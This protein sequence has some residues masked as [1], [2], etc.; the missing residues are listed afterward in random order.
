MKKNDA[1]E[2]KRFF[3]GFMDA[4][5]HVAEKSSGTLALAVIQCVV[6][7]ASVLKAG[8]LDSIESVILWGVAVISS[9]GFFVGAC[10]IA[11]LILEQTLSSRIGKLTLL[12]LFL[13]VYTGVLLTALLT[14]KSL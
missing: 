1:E 7:A 14:V 9:I 4:Y 12:V 5:H 8:E 3:D 10:I 13:P 2:S 11:A 6:T